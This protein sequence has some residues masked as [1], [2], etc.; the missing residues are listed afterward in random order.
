MRRIGTL[1]CS[2]VVAAACTKLAAA[3][4]VVAVRWRRKGIGDVE[5][6]PWQLTMN[7]AVDGV[8]GLCD[9]GCC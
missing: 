8:K 5:G 2:E 9:R 7:Y 6:F 4:A 1:A 3:A